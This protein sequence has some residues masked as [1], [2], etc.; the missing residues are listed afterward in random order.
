MKTLVV[1]V[2]VILIACLSSTSASGTAQV[3]VVNASP[4]PV[5]LKF[6]STQTPLVGD[7][8]GVTGYISL[9]VPDQG[10]VLVNNNSSLPFPA[11]NVSLSNNTYYTAI[12]SEIFNSVTNKTEGKLTFNSDS[13]LA[14]NFDTNF[15]SVAVRVYNLA[16]THIDFLGAENDQQK[17]LQTNITAL[18][19]S[20]YYTLSRT[21]TQLWVSNAMASFGFNV[22]LYPTTVYTLFVYETVYGNASS[23]LTY[24]LTTDYFNA[25]NSNVRVVQ[26]IPDNSADLRFQIAQGNTSRTQNNVTFFSVSPYLVV[27]S[28]QARLELVYSKNSS[29]VLTPLPYDLAPFNYYSV[30]YY[31]FSNDSIS[32]ILNDNNTQDQHFAKVRV[33]HLV[34][35][36]GNTTV[37]VG[38]QGSFLN[39]VGSVSDYL[40][41]SGAN[42]LK[43]NVSGGASQVK[44][45]TYDFANNTVYTVW[46][47]GVAKQVV[48]TVTQDYPLPKTNKGLS[49]LELGLI[50]GGAILFVI[51]L[52]A[53]IIFAV[54]SRPSDGYERIEN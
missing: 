50:I 17:P 10:Q 6:G 32:L 4:Q 36:F 43:I 28:T 30:V 12:V 34:E 48:V 24:N 54:R 51:L 31:G 46:L 1:A 52:L 53:I 20:N 39:E 25:N 7:Y 33:V 11:Q 19:P 15:T 37:I 26:G 41:L 29:Y 45:V 3:R 23:P 14:A 2:L 42:N 21:V 38:N 40:Y 5:Q 27:P 16:S 49:N 35:N 22:T 9:P 13:V 18:N 47:Q 44:P 8:A